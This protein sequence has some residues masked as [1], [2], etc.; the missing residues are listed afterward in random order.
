MT[1]RK[2]NETRLRSRDSIVGVPP[3]AKIADILGR[4]TGYSATIHCGRFAGLAM[5]ASRLRT[6]WSGIAMAVSQIAIGL[7]TYQDISAEDTSLAVY[8]ALK[9]TSEKLLPEYVN[10]YEP[11]NIPVANHEDWKTHWCT[12]ATMRTDGASSDVRFGALWRRR[13]SLQGWGQ[14]QFASRSHKA[15][16]SSLSLHYN[17]SPKVDWLALFRDL[18]EITVPAYAMLHLFTAEEIEANRR[19]GGE[20]TAVEHFDGAVTGE[21]CFV[22]SIAPDGNLRRPDSWDRA[23]RRTFRFLPQ[24]SWANHLGAEFDGQY[25]F[26]VIRANADSVIT[27]E[28]FVAFTISK[29]LADVMDDYDGFAQR[30]RRLRAAFR[31]G[32]FRIDETSALAK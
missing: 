15:E 17:W 28:D 32:F 20:K 14:A 26:D 22:T 16:D 27:G 2:P 4:I 8:E 5:M 12:D 18:C 3:L 24:L 1:I 7:T 31:D 9:A 29:R 25:D 21:T 10:W 11:V 30:R 6:H 23:A 19:R 13:H